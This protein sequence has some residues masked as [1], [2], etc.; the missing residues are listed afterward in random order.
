MALLDL[1]GLGADKQAVIIDIGV[2]F[3]KIGL[4]GEQVPRHIVRTELNKIV[5]SKMESIPLLNRTNSES[6]EQDS[7]YSLFKDFF[8]QVYF[9]YLLVNPKERRVIICDS[10][11]KPIEVRNLIA[12][13][14]FKHFEVVSVVFMPSHL[15]ALFT[16]GLSSGLVVDVGFSETVAVPVYEQGTIL[17]G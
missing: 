7:L 13:I 17:N 5:K 15:L 16:C 3:T 10:M 1:M 11:L 6:D 12:K 9:Q 14:L 4:A 2:A 8:H